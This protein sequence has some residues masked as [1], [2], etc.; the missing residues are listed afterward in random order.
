MHAA[1]NLSP[2]SLHPHLHLQ[3]GDD[4]TCSVSPQDYYVD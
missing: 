3:H 4:N 2:I 1:L